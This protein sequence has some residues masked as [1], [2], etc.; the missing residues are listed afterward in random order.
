MSAALVM[1]PIVWML[2]GALG[3]GLQELVRGRS[4]AGLMVFRDFVTVFRLEPFARF[5]LNSIG[6]TGVIVLSQVVTSALAAYGLV[7]TRARGRRLIFALVLVSMMIPIQAIF[8]PDYVLL[9]DLRW[10]NTYQALIVPFLGSGFGIFFLRQAFIRIPASLVEAMQVDG[11]THWTI[12]TRLVMP[13]TRS[14]QVTL[15]LVNGIFQYGYLF[16][17]L[18]VTN[19]DQYR[20]VPVGLSYLGGGIH[21]AMAGAIMAALPSIGAFAWGQRYLV[22]EGMLTGVKG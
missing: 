13:V 15:A 6:I 4:H 8:I 19:T 2:W 10:V 22:R 9:A 20:V 21:A 1:L 3:P 17:P 12:W 11:A 16:W 5:F 7:F 18:L 14:S